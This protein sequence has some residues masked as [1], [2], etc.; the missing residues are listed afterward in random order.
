MVDPERLMRLLAALAAELRA[1]GVTTL[2][3]QETALLGHPVKPI[4]RALSTIYDNIVL[5]RYLELHGSLYRLISILKMRESDYDSNVRELFIA[6]SGIT[7]AA[8]PESA[9]EILGGREPSRAERIA[10]PED[11][12]IRAP[13]KRTRRRS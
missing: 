13:L 5:L 4:P 3:A 2:F 8:T 9:A 12:R 1:R 10:R 11:E 6:P 7:L